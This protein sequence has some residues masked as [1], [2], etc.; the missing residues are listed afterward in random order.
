[1]V[2][3][4]QQT[5]T[6]FGRHGRKK[7]SFHRPITKRNQEGNSLRA[8]RNITHGKR[9]SCGKSLVPTVSLTDILFIRHIMNLEAIN[10][11]DGKYDVKMAS[12]QKLFPPKDSSAKVTIIEGLQVQF[13]KPIPTG[14][15]L[16][17]FSSLEKSWA[18]DIGH[19]KDKNHMG[20][21]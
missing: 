20:V 10:T 13:P 7:K 14:N 4:F 21:G 2:Y 17:S 3:F 12:Q 19:I 6:F 1:M 15:F 16:K 18:V 9:N 11:Y 8:N 5:H